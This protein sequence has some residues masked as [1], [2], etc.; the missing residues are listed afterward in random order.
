MNA[1]LIQHASQVNWFLSN[2]YPHQN[3]WV[4]SVWSKL[5]YFS[6]TNKMCQ[7]FR[8]Q[9]ERRIKS[10]KPS[11]CTR[12]GS[13]NAMLI[14]EKRRQFISALVVY[15]NIDLHISLVVFVK[16]A[17]IFRWWRFCIKTDQ[18]WPK[19]ETRWISWVISIL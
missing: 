14:G 15:S 7:T 9:C 13:F 4:V 18:V 1:I 19:K 17:E 2:L 11:F 16:K 10:I 5:F 6:L 8:T 12:N 3:C